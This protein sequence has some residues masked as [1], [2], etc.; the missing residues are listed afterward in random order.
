MLEAIK[1]TWI[2]MQIKANRVEMA[3]SQKRKTKYSAKMVPRRMMEVYGRASL[4]RIM[5]DAAKGLPSAQFSRM[6]MVQGRPRPRRMAKMFEAMAAEM[7]IEAAFVF[8]ITII[9]V[10]RSGTADPA[11]RIVMPDTVGGMPR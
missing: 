7:P 3:Q 6:R 4:S 8:L 2:D 1:R 10:T 11:A 5:Y 9:E